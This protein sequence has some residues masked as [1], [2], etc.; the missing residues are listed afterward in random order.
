VMCGHYLYDPDFCNVASGWEKGIVEKNVQDSRRRIWIDAAKERF[1][2]L[3]ELNA[4]VATRCRALWHETQHPEHN[5]FSVAE[6][7]EHEREHL[8]PMTAPFDGYVEEAARV[9]T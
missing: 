6:M 7:L 4:W 1:A 2:N 9:S 3:A 5:Q 8:M